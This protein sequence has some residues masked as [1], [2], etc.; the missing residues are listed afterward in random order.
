MTHWAGH[1][2]L[3]LFGNKNIIT[4]CGCDEIERKNMYF[5]NTCILKSKKDTTLQELCL[6]RDK[7]CVLWLTAKSNNIIH[8]CHH[9]FNIHLNLMKW[10]SKFFLLHPS[11]LPSG[12][13]TLWDRHFESSTEVAQIEDS[14]CRRFQGSL[15]GALQI[16]LYKKVRQNSR[17]SPQK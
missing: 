6:E 2:N 1:F 13:L 3:S 14:T 9:A 11:W 16:N 8:F 12:V 10:T 7:T 17:I 5:W 15:A 4:L